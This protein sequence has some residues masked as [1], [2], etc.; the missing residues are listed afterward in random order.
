MGGV[1]LLSP[2]LGDPVVWRVEI[3]ADISARLVSWENPTGDLSISNLEMAAYLV[4]YIVLEY[5][6]TLRHKKRGG[7]RASAL[8]VEGI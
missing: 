2:M 3:P 5:V 4:Q 1:W 7:I 6:V 8:S